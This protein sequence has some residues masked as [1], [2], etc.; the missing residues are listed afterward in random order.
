M[1][2]WAAFGVVGGPVIRHVQSRFEIRLLCRVPEGRSI[3]ESVIQ[4]S[5]RYP[6]FRLRDPE[7]LFGIRHT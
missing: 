5:H 2:A 6:F 4:T 1:T 7:P 3:E